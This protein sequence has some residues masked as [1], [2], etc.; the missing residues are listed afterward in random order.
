MIS[1]L[2]RLARRA[3]S[4]R[5]SR[6]LS[7][8]LTLSV[9]SVLL[10]VLSALYFNAES[11]MALELSGVPNMVVEPRQS[12]VSTSEL[13]IDDLRA[14]KS[15]AH[16]WRNNIAGVAPI[17]KSVVNIDGTSLPVAGTWFQET[18]SVESDTLSAGLL[19][20][21][22]W[23]YEGNIPGE[24]QVV[25]GAQTDV[26][27]PVTLHFNGTAYTFS[28]AGTLRTG[29]YWDKYLFVDLDFL[30]ATIQRE[31]LDQ[32]LVSSLIKP[33]DELAVRAEQYG[34]ESLSLEEFEQWYCS[35]YASSIAYTIQEVIPQGDVRVLR[36]ITEVQE[37]MIRASSGVFLALFALTLIASV[38]AISGAERMYIHA[39]LKDF[40]IMAALGSS[41]A[42]IFAQVLTEI[43]L[44]SL[45]A[46]FI[47]YGISQLLIGFL[48]RVLFAIPFEAH[49]VLLVG[50]VTVPLMAAVVS[51]FLLRKELRKD[52]VRLLK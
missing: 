23:S 16:F 46:G 10:V 38:T 34:E 12:I 15:E 19:T 52:I 28:V 8:A 42:K 50:S 29:S 20:F 41:R 39:H 43:G 45:L 49:A 9:A 18:F 13:R 51:F 37:G 30:Q 4:I 1:F 26:A 5:K 33:K 47:T 40:G 2:F 22:G 31:T 27:S 7:L 44:A 25:A 14:L 21:K 6:F 17:Q 11:R 24:R 48:S 35:P 3:V 36:R 32:I